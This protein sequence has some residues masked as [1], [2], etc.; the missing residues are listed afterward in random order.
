ME[1]TDLY[2][3]LLHSGVEGKQVHFKSSVCSLSKTM[4]YALK[5]FS[6]MKARN[7]SLIHLSKNRKHC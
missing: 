2:L 4:T 1:K 5:T 6:H 3:E 7:P